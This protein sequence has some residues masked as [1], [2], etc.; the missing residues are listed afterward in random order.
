MATG[1]A[2]GQVSAKKLR[3][4]YRVGKF[5]RDARIYGVIADP[6]SHSISP[7]VHNRAFQAKR[8]DASYLPFLVKPGQLKDFFAMAEDLPLA[9]FSVTIPHKQKII[10]Y[11]DKVDLVAKRIGAVNTVWR[12]AGKWHGTNTDAPGVTVPL[13]QHLRLNKSSILVVG[14]GGAAR[15]AAFA[16]AEAGA[17]LS[18]TGRN[19]D[20]VRALASACGAEP[21]SRDQAEARGFDAVVHATPLGM[22]PNLDKCFFK[23]KIPAKLVFDMV[24]NPIETELLKRARAQRAVVIPGIEMFIEQASRQFE[25]WTG[26]RAP[27]AVME[28]AALEALNGKTT[29]TTASK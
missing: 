24:Y 9:G 3:S 7:A 22:A 18:L 23:D 1:T 25:I 21:L 2:S 27:R 28:Q 15:G 12:K 13:E 19:I 17:K 8:I 14:N 6:V 20:R 16:L 10:R 4:L 29:Q 11:L 5:S 26:Q